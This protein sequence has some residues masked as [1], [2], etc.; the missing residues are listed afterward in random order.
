M[1]GGSIHPV[2]QGGK[3]AKMSYPDVISEAKTLDLIL[4]GHSIARYGDGEFNIVKGGNCVSQL[5]DATMQ[6]ELQAILRSG[7]RQCLI[8]I[9]SMNP[10]GPK[11]ANWGKYRESYARFLRPTKV[12]YSAFITRPDSA[13]W[14]NTAEY[15][16]KIESLWR[17][18]EV[19][20]VYGTDRSLS[21]RFAPMQSAKQIVEVKCARRDAYAEIDILEKQVRLVGTER[22]LLCCGPTATCLAYRLAQAGHHAIDLGHIAMFWRLY[23]RH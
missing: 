3:M 14:I 16:D 8:G 1:N 22:V 10:L 6:E 17:D 11:A 4:D 23:A 12:Y 19:T 18:Q 5:Y 7:D 15:F 2:Q 13:P 9:P 20:L 21:P